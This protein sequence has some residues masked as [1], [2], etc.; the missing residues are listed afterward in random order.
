MT[1]D[2]LLRRRRVWD[3]MSALFLDTET[4][5]YV[6]RVA[7]TLLDSGYSEDALNRIWLHEAVPEFYANLLSVAGEW[8]VLDFNEARMIRRTEKRGA[9][10][11]FFDRRR[12]SVAREIWQ[13][14]LQL[15]A[16]LEP[17]PPA[18]RGKLAA[19]WT[20][21]AHAWTENDISQ[22]MF[23]DSHVA[24]IQQTGL[25]FDA[26]QKSLELCFLPAFNRLI[27]E[28]E[29]SQRAARQRNARVLLE[30]ALGPSRASH[31]GPS[32]PATKDG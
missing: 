31:S 29:A 3:A 2:E 14:T 15:R 6:P 24:A 8:A 7:L 9:L 10:A 1:P 18:S 19:L 28:S 21:L 4:R 17:Q 27:Y 25:S 20:A 16:N 23:V 22:V 26:C 13:A 11:R 5:W 32:E 12:A 30:R